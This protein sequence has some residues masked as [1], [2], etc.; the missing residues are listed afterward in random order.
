M[1]HGDVTSLLSAAADHPNEHL[2]KYVH[3]LYSQQTHVSFYAAATSAAETYTAY[4][5]GLLYYNLHASTYNTENHHSETCISTLS[6]MQAPKYA[7]CYNLAE[8]W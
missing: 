7:C 4:L 8:A 3:T 6:A 5:T 2:G 1:H